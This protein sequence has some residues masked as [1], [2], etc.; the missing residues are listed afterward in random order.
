MVLGVAGTGHIPLPVE[1]F[2]FC[3]SD[4]KAHQQSKLSD[5]GRK[6]SVYIERL[7]T[8]LERRRRMPSLKKEHA[9]TA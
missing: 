2:A 7:L 9:K 3:G 1:Y 5:H 4:N 6:L 8:H